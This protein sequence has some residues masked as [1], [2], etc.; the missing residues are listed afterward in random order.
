MK[1]NSHGLTPIAQAASIWNKD[2]VD[3]LFT[4]IIVP[5]LAKKMTLNQGDRF[6]LNKVVLYAINHYANNYNELM[7]NV[8]YLENFIKDLFFYGASG[9]HFHFSDTLQNALHITAQKGYLLKKILELLI[10]HANW[11]QINKL[12]YKNKLP[13]DYAFD[14]N[15]DEISKMLVQWESKKYLI[16][17]FIIFRGQ[18]LPEL[19]L[20]VKIAGYLSEL[21]QIAI[22]LLQEKIKK[23]PDYDFIVK[24]SCALENHKKQAQADP[25]SI[26]FFKKV[27]DSLKKNKIQDRAS[28]A[29]SSMQEFLRDAKNNQGSA[30]ASLKKFGLIPIT[31]DNQSNENKDESPKK[32]VPKFILSNEFY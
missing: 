15:N 5:N 2:I 16:S 1:T 21:D 6:Q 32:V 30:I 24:A 20:F 3:Y 10:Q 23:L 13:L 27:E 17:F 26:A 18:R 4:Q 14:S 29:Q 25:S 12:D 9:C 22:N 31:N 7:G 8:K 28:E 11:D 19:E